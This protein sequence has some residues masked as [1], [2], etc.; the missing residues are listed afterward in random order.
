MNKPKIKI[1]KLTIKKWYV[2]LFF[3]FCFSNLSCG[4]IITQK[5]AHNEDRA[6]NFDMCGSSLPN[7]YS[8]TRFDL[9]VIFSP[10][11]CE[12]SGGE[13]ALLGTVLYPFIAA[14]FIVDLPLSFVSDTLILPYTGYRQAVYGNIVDASSKNRKGDKGKK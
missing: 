13:S 1:E 9:G 3:I 10:F 5:I 7:A 12:A 6:K 2:F 11:T 4:T 14:C 8:G